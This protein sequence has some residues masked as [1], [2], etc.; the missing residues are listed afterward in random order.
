MLS[1]KIHRG[2]PRKILR[3]LYQ[4]LGLGA[5]A[6]VFQACYGIPADNQETGIYGLVKSGADDKPI[7][8][9]DVTVQGFKSGHE[10]TS[11]DGYFSFIV[12]RQKS[13]ILKFEDVD[14]SYNGGLFKSKELT[15]TLTDASRSLDIYLDLDD[16]ETE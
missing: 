2:L 4:S 12:P 6:M 8:G 14:G 13:Y 10:R 11:K 9:I 16:E 7:P 15:V 5:V 1:G 3:K